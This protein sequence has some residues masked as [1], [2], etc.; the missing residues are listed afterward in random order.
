MKNSL[1]IFAFFLAAIF[2]AISQ[3]QSPQFRA[4]AFYSTDTETDHVLFAQDAVEFFDS[5]AKK[6]NFVFDSTIDWHNLN[7]TY[8]KDYQ[9]VLWLNG[10]PTDPAQLAQALSTKEVRK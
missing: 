1:A 10:S 2:P 9:L 6:D 3:A 5:L 7:E 4:V 8:L